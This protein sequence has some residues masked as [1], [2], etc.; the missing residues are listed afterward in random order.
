[1]KPAL[2]PFVLALSSLAAQQPF[3]ASDWLPDDYR[4]FVQ[5]DLKA[6]RDQGVWDELES[7]ALKM[8]FTMMEKEAGFALTAL[9]RVTQVAMFPADAP[10]G[11]DAQRVVVLEGNEELPVPERI[12]RS[13]SYQPA[14][15]GEFEVMRSVRDWLFFRPR[16]EVQ[17][18]GDL[19]VL[20]H[21]LEGKPGLGAPC[22]DILSLRSTR[23]TSL[24]E[25]AVDLTAELPRQQVLGK[26]FAGHEWPAGDAPQLVYGRLHGTGDADDPH[27]VCEVVLRHLKAGEGLATT[28]K[29]LDELFAK[30]QEVP[31][32][33]M[34]RPLIAAIERSTDHGDLIL[35]LDLGR[36]RDAAGKLAMAMAPLLLAGERVEAQNV[37]AV[38]APAPPPAPDKKKP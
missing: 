36:A 32:A 3:K 17:V 19:A 21:T 16:P 27:V 8:L 26:L 6:L 38:P 4:N 1:M 23:K 25:F 22:A 33:A 24:I 34:L 2:A 28:A 35:K 5:V 18:E 13:T 29:A 37:P 7:S 30:A 20:Q 31:Q 14:K 9:D 11:Q 12:A 10:P 15:V